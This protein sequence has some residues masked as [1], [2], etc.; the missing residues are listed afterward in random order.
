LG[1]TNATSVAGS[2][3]PFTGVL[4]IDNSGSTIAIGANTTALTIGKSTTIA[5]FAGGVTINGAGAADILTVQKDGI[6]TTKTIGGWVKNATNSGTQVTPQFPIWSAFNG[7]TQVNLALQ[8]EPQSTSRGL[9]KFYYGT[10]T[11]APASGGNTYYDVQDSN[12]GEGIVSPGFYISSAIAGGFRF[13]NSSNRGGMDLDGSSNLRLKS[14]S[15][16]GFLLAI[17]SDAGSTLT[18]S[19][20]SVNGS[21]K[22]RVVLIPHAVTSS[23]SAVTFPLATCEHIRHS[24]TEA[25]TVSFTGATPGMRG[26]LDFIQGG[27]GYVVTM[28]TNGVGVEYSADL[29]ALG[30]T[31]IVD[32]TANTRTVLTYYVTDSPNTRVYITSRSVTNPIP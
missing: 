18:S 1:G 20:I 6:G 2:G 32:A 28:P 31:G 21:G 9:L 14:Y 5:T 17:Y 23:G 3:L 13:M 26:V 12:F 11:T 7:G 4:S 27:T 10:G 19:P 30:V 16:A 22:G 24:T 29:V 8:W 15:A 25:T